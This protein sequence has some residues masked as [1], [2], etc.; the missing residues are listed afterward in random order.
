[1]TYYRPTHSRMTGWV[2]EKNVLKNLNPNKAIDQFFL[3]SKSY[4]PYNLWGGV[5][6]TSIVFDAILEPLGVKIERWYFLT[7]PKYNHR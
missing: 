3:K 6:K 4:Q 1:M 7:F 2:K 5:F